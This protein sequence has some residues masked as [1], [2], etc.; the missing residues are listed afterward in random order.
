MRK[1]SIGI[2]TL[3]D[4]SFD[5][6]RQRDL[7]IKFRYLLEMRERI[8]FQISDL[9]EAVFTVEVEEPKRMVAL[10]EIFDFPKTNTGI[11]KE[12]CIENKGEIPVYGCS[13]EEGSVLGHIEKNLA[14]VKYYHDSL[15]WNRNGSV[16][17]IFLR[18]GVFSTNEDH[19]VISV[20]PRFVG[21]ID[22]LFVKHILRNRI[23]MLGFEF[24]NKLGKS[25]MMKTEIEI[26]IDSAGR[27]DLVRQRKIALRYAALYSTKETAI[28]QLDDLVK[29]EVAVQG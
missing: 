6:E 8:N 12:F 14:R 24:T 13:K 22:L 17:H 21:E 4:G 5:V 26:P 20:K 19:R 25:K 11:T 23:R 27:Y 9:K 29:C 7:A 3:P 16:G 2:P 18:N 10:S 15:S 28:Q 1:A